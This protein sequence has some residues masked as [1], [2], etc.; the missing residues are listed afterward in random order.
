MTSKLLEQ[1]IKEAR[2]LPEARQN[3]AAEML[4][5]LVAQDPG[6]I[7]LDE[8]QLRDLQA[9]LNDAAESRASEDEVAALY[10]RLGV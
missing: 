5:G 10:Q 3:E 1:A 7:S 2:K 9:R 4:L 6:S 8:A